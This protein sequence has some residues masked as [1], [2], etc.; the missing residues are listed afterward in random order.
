[1]NECPSCNARVR[2]GQE[3]CEHCGLPLEEAKPRPGRETRIEATPKP[4]P[5]LFRP[6]PR[7]TRLD[8]ADPFARSAS[9]SSGPAPAI[10]PADPFERAITGASKAAPK[11][12]RTLIGA[13][14]S[15]PAAHADDPFAAALNPTSAPE[16]PLARPLAGM[17]VSFSGAPNGRL[18]PLTL[19]R[20]II[21]RDPGPAGPDV[22][23]LDDDSVSSRHCVVVAREAGVMVKDEMSSNGT[24]HRPAGATGFRDILAETVHLADGDQIK[25]GETILLLRLLD[26]ATVDAI[27][28]GP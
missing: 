7:A 9:R 4:A 11:R 27:W 26:R 25:V 24:L 22:I 17:L 14:A 18:I 15:R 8:A 12:R 13:A 6:A 21:G 19:G 28:G 1:M 2:P 3:E 20:T 5:G 16:A 23:A 10:D